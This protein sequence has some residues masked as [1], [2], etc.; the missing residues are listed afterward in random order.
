VVVT[1]NMNAQKRGEAVYKLRG[2][3]NVPHKTA[4]RLSKYEPVFRN[5]QGHG[6]DVARRDEGAGF[7]E[8]T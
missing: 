7:E 2:K 6:G 8:M 1:V 4:Q 3:H 5:P